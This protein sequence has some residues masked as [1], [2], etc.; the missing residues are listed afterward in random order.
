MITKSSLAITTNTAITVLDKATSWSEF[1]RTLSPKG[2]LI[3]T[4]KQLKS[5]ENRQR[6]KV[7]AAKAMVTTTLV[8]LM[9]V[10]AKWGIANLYFK[11]AENLLSD[12][13]KTYAGVVNPSKNYAKVKEPS[14]T[15][16]FKLEYVEMLSSIDTAIFLH[17]HPQYLEKK[18][19]IYEWAVRLNIQPLST[20]KYAN[21][22]Y[23]QSTE[24]RPTWPVTWAAL[25]LNKWHLGE[26]DQHMMHYLIKAHQYGKNTPEVQLVW[27]KFIDKLQQS[28]E[29]K[30]K[31]MMQQL[32]TPILYY[33]NL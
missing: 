2:G 1:I 12:T 28:N 25:A 17:Q 33:Q 6:L 14:S 4:L 10:A 26:F 31:Q 13:T 18:A 15:E 21:T 23:L 30:L 19:Q 24:L 8:L 20:L 32:K 11:S 27:L 9:L 29:P 16:H 5:A 22:L 3:R 7:P